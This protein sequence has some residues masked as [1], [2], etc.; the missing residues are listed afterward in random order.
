VMSGWRRSISARFPRRCWAV[1][2]SV[3]T[4]MLAVCLSV[5]A[6]VPAAAARRIHARDTVDPTGTTTVPLP[7]VDGSVDPTPGQAIAGFGAS[8][9]WWPSAA[10]QFPAAVRDQIGRLL[11]G[12]DGLR[13]SQY[14]YN[15]GGGGVG[16]TD[17][18]KASPSFLTSSGT[19]DWDADPY[20]TMFLR[21]AHDYH[22]PTLVGFVN[23]APPQ[24]TSDGLSCGGQLVPADIPAY[25]RYLADVVDHLD[26]LG[27][28]LSYVSP[29]N[30]PDTSQ[31]RCRQE[32]MSVP[33]SERAALVDAV[34]QAL[35]ATRAQP[36]VI[37]D[38]SSLVAQLLEELP[39][40]L[41]QADGAVAVVA[42]HTYDYPTDGL[43]E[44]VAQLTVPHW[45]TEICCY[46]G[47]GFGPGYDPTMT[48]GIWLAD[49]IY[50]D[51]GVAH[52]SAFDWWVANLGCDPSAD[53]T[54]PYRPNPAGRNDG[55][56]YF[57]PDWQ[58][59]HDV[60]LFP[61]KRYAVLASFSRFVRPGAVLH[62]VNGLPDGVKALAF[63]RGRRWTVVAIND[64]PTRAVR[65]TVQL[66]SGADTT[67]ASGYLTDAAAN[68]APTDVDT[69][70]STAAFDLP[71][72][73]V[74]T[75]VV[76][77]PATA[78]HR[79][80]HPRARHAGRTRSRARSRR[81]P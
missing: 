42:H 69:S 23:S 38:E 8:G 57:D 79:L 17:A 63:T 46:D 21:Q 3:L 52:D 45:A 27:L 33:V 65:L 66:P 77:P 40:W 25:A 44:Q 29:V 26:S 54:C 10:G 30:E 55:L 20:G 5:V 32:G 11:F 48:D 72:Q 16:V 9:A 50:A 39:Q 74:V 41:P 22:V 81:R 75:V 31:P 47:S 28:R 24:F 49:T 64:S 78:G 35:R 56:V 37:A 60:N 19:Y 58:A 76:G 43:L 53:P 62:E 73:S 14:R 15:I 70:A 12:P 6:A 71:T 36:R 4:P 7:A 80:A 18:Y 68:L 2:V 67:T 61:T 1:L 13:L 34:A 51:L 59:D